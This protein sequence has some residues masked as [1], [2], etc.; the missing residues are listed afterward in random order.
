[1]E[2]DGTVEVRVQ[3]LNEEIQTKTRNLERF[4]QAIQRMEI[5]IEQVETDH[6]RKHRRKSIRIRVHR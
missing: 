4:E 1:M 6:R 5:E 2:W 3:R